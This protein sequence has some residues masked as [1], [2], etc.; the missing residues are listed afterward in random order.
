MISG[1]VVSSRSDSGSRGLVTRVRSSDSHRLASSVCESRPARRAGTGETLG[2]VDR[3]TTPCLRCVGRRMSPPSSTHLPAPPASASRCSEVLRIIDVHAAQ[4][5]GRG[6]S[7]PLPSTCVLRVGLM[8]L[9]RSTHGHCASLQ[10]CVDRFSPASTAGRNFSAVTPTTSTMC[11]GHGT[12][13]TAIRRRAKANRSSHVRAPLP[14]CV[15][16]VFVVSPGLRPLDARPLRELGA[17]RPSTDASFHPT[18]EEPTTDHTVAESRDE[19]RQP[20]RAASKLR[21]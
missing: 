12:L 13:A 2:A 15:S 11:T 14:T 18:S 16:G 6:A 1:T 20:D 8:A 10:P 4:I 5:C 7:E 17:V 9:L 19:R 21:F 3:K